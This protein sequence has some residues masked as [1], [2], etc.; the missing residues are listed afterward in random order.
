[1]ESGTLPPPCR[2]L[3][4]RGRCKRTLA[5]SASGWKSLERS[6]KNF[7]SRTFF[8]CTPHQAAQ[9]PLDKIP[10]ASSP[11]NDLQPLSIINNPL[12]HTTS[13]ISTSPLPFPFSHSR[14]CNSICT[15]QL[16]FCDTPQPPLFTL[17]THSR[18]NN[19]FLHNKQSPW[20]PL[21]VL[22][23]AQ[24][25]LVWVCSVMTALRCE[26]LH[27]SL[28]KPPAS[29]L[30]FGTSPRHYHQPLGIFTEQPC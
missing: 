20:L 12:Y 9:Q 24:P 15:R 30:R 19:T 27:V 17:T 13:E 28:E 8:D 7:L 23:W 1:M 5:L 18:H 21:L 11:S 29:P 6:S 16:R 14:F 2:Y 10:T 3:A 25:T 22:I 26:Y 4:D